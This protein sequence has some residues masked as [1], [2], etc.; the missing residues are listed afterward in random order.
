MKITGV[1]PI[2]V[3]KEAD[4]IKNVFEDLGFEHRH[5]KTGIEGGQNTNFNKITETE[6]AKSTMLPVSGIP[7]T[8]KREPFKALL[9]S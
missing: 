6:S 5:T 1:C 2:I 7:A 8:Q 3:S 9:C 4:N